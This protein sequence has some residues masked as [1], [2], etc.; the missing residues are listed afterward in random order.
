MLIKNT[1]TYLYRPV[2]KQVG[3]A[4]LFSKRPERFKKNPKTLGKLVKLLQDI[5]IR[6]T[7]MKITCQKHSGSPVYCR[8]NLMKVK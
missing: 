7:V 2:E 3:Q 8:A 5:A 4:V 6:I 1:L